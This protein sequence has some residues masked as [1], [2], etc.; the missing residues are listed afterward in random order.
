MTS[1]LKRLNASAAAR[2]ANWHPGQL[3]IVWLIAV[4]FEATLLWQHSELGRRVERIERYWDQVFESHQRNLAEGGYI[5][6]DGTLDSAQQ[7]ADFV[8]WLVGSSREIQDAQSLRDLLQPALVGAMLVVLATLL[9]L[10]WL[11]FANRGAAK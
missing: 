1:V 4:L 5:R 8:R 2:V 6:P 10:S 11:W 7:N 3:A 9:V